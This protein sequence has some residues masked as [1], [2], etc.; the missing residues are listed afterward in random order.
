MAQ[1]QKGTTVKVGF[2]SFSYTG[3]VPEDA[4]LSYPNGNVE[5]IK[6]ANGATQT[7][8]AMDPAKQQDVTLIILAAGAI[9]PPIEQS[10]ISLTPN[11]GAA[12]SFR[13]L[14]ASVKF[15]A[16]ASRLSLS[17]IK[18]DSMSYTT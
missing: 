1:I 14:S 2:G 18:E 3:Y 11:W 9:D 13:V 17:L 10:I 5:V 7:I 12:T 8:I 4:T 16:G 6:D 15:V